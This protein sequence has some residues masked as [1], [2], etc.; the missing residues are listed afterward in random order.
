MGDCR[1]VIDSYVELFCQ[2]ESGRVNALAFVSEEKAKVAD[3]T[4]TLWSDPAF[5]VDETYSGDIVIHQKVS[6][7]YSASDTTGPGKGTQTERLIGKVH[8][9]TTRV[10]SVKGNNAYWDDLNISQAY[11]P[12]W[13]GDYYQV[14]MVG[15]ANAR[16]SAN[17]IQEDALDSLLEWEVVSIWSDIRLPQTYDVP[18]G[19]FN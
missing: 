8:T 5:W 11:R 19:I 2:F 9:L 14:L 12:V 15:T 1:K 10:E 18:A 17:M 16:I 4:P 6:G 3:A 7:S 13:V